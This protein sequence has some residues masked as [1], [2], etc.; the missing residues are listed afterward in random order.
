MDICRVIHL[1]MLEWFPLPDSAEFMSYYR[2]R[3]DHDR[4]LDM[5][6]CAEA[7]A[8]VLPKPVEYYSHSHQDISADGSMRTVLFLTE[9]RP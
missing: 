5:Y 8:R 4:D 9:R 3:L 2:I 1:S 7:V 6:S